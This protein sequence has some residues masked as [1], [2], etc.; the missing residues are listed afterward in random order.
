[1]QKVIYSRSG[2][3]KFSIEFMDELFRQYGNDSTMWGDGMASTPHIFETTR[4]ICF[5]FSRHILYPSPE[6]YYGW[7]HNSHRN[8][9]YDSGRIDVLRTG[10]EIRD[11]ATGNMLCLRTHPKVV[12]LVET[13]NE[14]GVSAGAD[15]QELGVRRIP[16]HW[17]YEVLR[18]WGQETIVEKFPWKEVIN[19]FLTGTPTHPVTLDLLEKKLRIEDYTLRAETNTL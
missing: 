8:M 7:V 2:N 19:D 11:R 3:L 10:G 15:G 9:W 13:W 14:Y 5:G 1:M 6:G 18:K 16:Q 4:T 17:G 12:D